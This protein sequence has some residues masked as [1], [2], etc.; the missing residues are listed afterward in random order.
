[1]V[2][3]PEFRIQSNY[4]VPFQDGEFYLSIIHIG[5]S[6]IVVCLPV[7]GVDMCNRLPFSYGGL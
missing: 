4:F 5:L 6:K 7:I 1:M 3:M 2:D